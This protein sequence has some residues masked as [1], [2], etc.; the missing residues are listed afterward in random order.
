MLPNHASEHECSSASVVGDIRMWKS[1]EQAHKE[2]RPM[3]SRPP[4]STFALLL[5]NYRLASRLTQEAL[6]ERANLT[7]AAIAALES[8]RRRRPHAD[9]IDRLATALALSD[10]ERAAFARAAHQ[11]AASPEEAIA[12]ALLPLESYLGATAGGPLVGRTEA[13]GVLERSVQGALGGAGRLVFVTGEPGIG[14]T[15]LVREVA[16]RAAARGAVVAAARCDEALRSV[17]YAPVSEALGALHAA[18]PRTL[19]DTVLQRW[20][21]LCRLLPEQENET[22]GSEQGL[23]RDGG[24]EDEPRLWRQALGFLTAL[25]AL[26]PVVVLFDD[27]HWADK[28]SLRLLGHLAWKVRGTRVLLL[29]AYRNTQLHRRPTLRKLL[30]NL[31]NQGL[32]ERVALGQL[33]LEETATLAH[34]ELGGGQVSD[35]LAQALQRA[36]EGNPFFLL[37]TVRLLRQRDELVLQDGRWQ[38]RV[39]GSDDPP[40]P[41]TVS[42]AIADR[43]A[44]LGSQAQQALEVASIFGQAFAYAPLRRMGG[45]SEAEVENALAEAQEAGLIVHVQSLAGHEA[46]HDDSNSSDGYAHDTPYRFSH[47]L[48]QQAIYLAI[49]RP[50][51]ARLHHAAGIALEDLPPGALARRAAEVAQHFLASDD[52]TRLERALPHV[53]T[54]GDY[55]YR[56]YA[57]GEAEQHYQRAVGVARELGDTAREARALEQLSDV[58]LG[59]GKYQNVGVTLMQAAALRRRLRDIDRLVWDTAH[60]SRVNSLLNR[61]E[62]GLAQLSA[63]LFEVATS[64]PELS[65][66]S[67]PTTARQNALVP[68]LLTLEQAAERTAQLVTHRTAGHL[69]LSLAVYLDY[70]GRWDASLHMVEQAI[71]HARVDRPNWILPRAHSF[72]VGSLHALGRTDEAEAAAPMSLLLA[73]ESGDADAQFL[74]HGAAAE[75][76]LLRGKFAQAK[77]HI[78]EALTA[79]DKSGVPDTILQSLYG[80]GMLDFIQGDWPEAQRVYERMAAVQDAMEVK[81]SAPLVVLL[82]GLLKIAQGRIDAAQA[83]LWRLGQ[84]DT[85]ENMAARARIQ[86]VFAEELL[87]SGRFT[88]ALERLRPLQTAQTTAIADLPPAFPMLAWAYAGCGKLAEAHEVLQTGIDYATAR[89][90]QSILA[91]ALRIEGMLALYEQKWEEAR[92]ALGQAQ[93]MSRSVGY[94]YAEAKAL[95]VYGQLHVAM[96]E[97]EQAREKYQAALVICD[98]L[99]ERLYRPH[100]ARDLAALIHV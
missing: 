25:A 7:L 66:Q 37:E 89:A 46:G 41:E 10:R 35:D 24:P 96:G 19:R 54:A 60:M 68:A 84:A 75:T 22:S 28:A 13:M 9:T 95:S 29:G 3:A 38:R 63:L 31:G 50:R 27:L 21:L 49:P 59:L 88:Q 48:M 33:A 100:I 56:L 47:A 80:L 39:S 92:Q 61:V 51:R 72:M 11:R 26:R 14:K 93:M 32:L 65:P 83:E 52:M 58:Y 16:L 70:L 86:A 57:W 91:D 23:G 44:H 30:A 67:T 12:A 73:D 20:P 76:A 36:T 94:P 74:A 1:G 17:A 98:R 97:P 64:P 6:A 53:L 87:L 4:S 78:S 81:H 42:Q 40:L 34:A 5:K 45:W 55:A 77:R 99:G 8:G 85:A 18:A 90:Y 43:V 15:R 82:G 69:Y 2:E 71:F 79:A 62:E